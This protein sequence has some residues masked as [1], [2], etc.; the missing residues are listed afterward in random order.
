M[1]ASLA[2]CVCRV[3]TCGSNKKS[4]NKIRG[5]KTRIKKKAKIPLFLSFLHV[6]AKSQSLSVRTFEMQGRRKPYG[7]R[8]LGRAW[9]AAA[10]TKVK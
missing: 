10:F 2:F 4:H 7:P 8:I 1:W 9:P 3:C 6:F 5:S